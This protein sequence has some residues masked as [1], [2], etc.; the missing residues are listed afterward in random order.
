MI[1]DKLINILNL[2]FQKL[3]IIV[4]ELLS[5]MF[6]TLDNTLYYNT[7]DQKSEQTLPKEEGDHK[8]V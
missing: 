5:K 1:L 7:E 2:F 3:D 4:Y 6:P 8:E